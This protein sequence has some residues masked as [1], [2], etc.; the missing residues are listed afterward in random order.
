MLNK[1]LLITSVL[2]F[3]IISDLFAN[4]EDDSLDESI[5]IIR[6]LNRIDAEEKERAAKRAFKKKEQDLRLEL[7]R[8]SAP[9][10]PP[11]KTPNQLKAEKK[12]KDTRMDS[13]SSIRSFINLQKI[14][15]DGVTYEDYIHQVSSVIIDK[16]YIVINPSLLSKSI[17]KLNNSLKTKESI[18]K[19]IYSMRDSLSLISTDNLKKVS[20]KLSRSN[21]LNKRGG[22]GISGTSTKVKKIYI[23]DD[24]FVAE[25]IKIKMVGPSL[26]KVY[27]NDIKFVDIGEQKIEYR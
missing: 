10:P 18:E 22:G 2:F 4:F 1:I 11:K 8:K 27:V 21:S 19:N 3:L 9:P 25:N 12:E 23:A 15:L 26:A 6:K 16:K 14:E 7:I 17:N 20:S 13:M 24:S 5:K